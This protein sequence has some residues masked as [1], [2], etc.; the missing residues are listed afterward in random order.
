LQIRFHILNK[1]Q[2]RSKQKNNDT[3]Q[4]DREGEKRTESYDNK[5]KQ[6]IK[7]TT[8]IM[9]FF[10]AEEGISPDNTYYYQYQFNMLE[11]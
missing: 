7:Y 4:F 6:K 8:K 10:V 11:I 2:Q 3:T 1:R 9:H 5:E